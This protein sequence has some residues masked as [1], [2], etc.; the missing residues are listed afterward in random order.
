M[1]QQGKKRQEPKTARMGRSGARSSNPDLPFWSAGSSGGR[2]RRQGVSPHTVLGASPLIPALMVMI[3][4][5]ALVYSGWLRQ[6]VEASGS[7]PVVQEVSA[8]FQK[9]PPPVPGAQVW[10]R[11]ESGFYYCRGNVLFGRGPGKL[12]R[13]SDALTSGY[14]PADGH[15]CIDGFREVHDS[16][17]AAPAQRH[18]Q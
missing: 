13:Q 16:G 3:G 8:L 9:D 15:Y 10:A 7:L 6:G 14:R 12:Q 2:G 4:V 18:H 5:I 11:K 17:H 1:A